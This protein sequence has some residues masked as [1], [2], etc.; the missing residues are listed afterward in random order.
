MLRKKLTSVLLTAAVATSTII[1]ALAAP[2]PFEDVPANAWYYQD[3]QTAYSTGLINGRSGTS[4]AP[5]A[6]LTYA[7]AVKLAACMNQKYTTGSI[8]L[9]NGSDNWYSTYVDYAKATR[10]ISKDYIWNAIATRAGYVEI[11]AHALP[12][13][14]LT[15]KNA[16]ADNAIPDVT[17]THPQAVEIYKLYRAGILAGND[18]KGTFYPNSNI[19][20]SEVAAILTRMMDSSARKSLSLGQSSVALSLDRTAASDVEKGIINTLVSMSGFDYSEVSVVSPILKEAAEQHILHGTDVQSFLKGKNINGTINTYDFDS[21]T[22]AEAFAYQLFLDYSP[23]VAASRYSLPYSDFGVAVAKGSDNTARVSIVTLKSDS[24][25]PVTPTPDP[26]PTPTP[27]PTPTPSTTSN[28]D[29][30]AQLY[31]MS[32]VELTSY[33]VNNLP[34]RNSQLDAAAA[35]LANGTTSDLDKALK[36][37]GFTKPYSS[38][39][40]YWQERYDNVSETNANAI[41]SYVTRQGSKIADPNFTNT[42]TLAYY[43]DLGIAVTGNDGAKTIVLV[44]YNRTPA[45]VEEPVVS[46]S[47]QFVQEQ[48]ALPLNASSEQTEML[49]MINAERAKVGASE[50]KML[51]ILNQL[52]EV[53]SHEYIDARNLYGIHTRLD[54]TK[55]WTI[56][57][58]YDIKKYILGSAENASLGINMDRTLESAM[59]GL[60]N[61]PGHKANLLNERMDYVGIYKYRNPATNDTT[62]IQLFINVG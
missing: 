57:D 32:G 24:A 8:S 51:P 45:E 59:S 2:V 56:F 26:N 16:V 12:D 11:F 61:S 48:L 50:L 22:N 25:T 6:N 47:E 35:L 58:E 13:A 54:G 40:T 49:Q 55:Y 10:I 43:D 14:A 62:W 23:V 15:Q 52:A 7:E 5:D 42:S 53:R 30:A 31:T 9:T 27:D 39:Y 18:S 3:V 34:S 44:M 41:L 46:A 33:G 60:M 20:R 4:F 28:T 17:I 19:R 36:S 37:A 1:P 21:F 38:A 29:L